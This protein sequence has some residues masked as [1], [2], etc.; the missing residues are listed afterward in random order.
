V[1]V[2]QGNLPE[3][4]KSYQD[5][6]AIFDQLAKSDPGNAGWQRDLAISF[7]RLSVVHKQSGDKAKA[8]DELRQ[9]QAIMARLT[10]SRRIMPCG[11]RT[12]LGSTGSLQRWTARPPRCGHRRAD[13]ITGE[14]RLGLRASDSKVPHLA[15]RA[16]SSSPLRGDT[17][18]PS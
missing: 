3:A 7:E 16:P 12:S 4:L 9:G 2:A 14:E 10:S 17:F 1:L 15:L 5:S 11:S 18:S 13:P 8:R 6:S